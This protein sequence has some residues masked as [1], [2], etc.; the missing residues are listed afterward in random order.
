MDEVESIRWLDNGEALNFTQKN[1]ILSVYATGFPYG[2][3][4]VVRVA[5]VT[6][7]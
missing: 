2:Q 4:L 5:E 1:G 6:V 3:Q 7:K